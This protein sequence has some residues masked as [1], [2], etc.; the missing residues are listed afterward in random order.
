MTDM[1]RAILAALAVTLAGCAA[2][3]E[4]VIR[5]G[6]DSIPEGIRGVVGMEAA[7]VRSLLGPPQSRWQIG[8][9]TWIYYYRDKGRDRDERLSAE[10]RFGDD[11]RVA[12][13]RVNEDTTGG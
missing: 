12:E 6:S 2:S 9:E 11:G 7:E 10:V 4:V 3:R 5:Q 13:V 8:G 1:F